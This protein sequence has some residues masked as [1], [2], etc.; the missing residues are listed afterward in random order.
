MRRSRLKRSI[1][2]TLAAT[3]LTAAP[4]NAAIT[5]TVTGDEL[6]VSSD[7]AGDSI[8]LTCSSGKVAVNGAAISGNPSCFAIRWVELHGN[9]GNDTLD[10]SSATLSQYYLAAMP[11]LYGDAGNDTLKGPTYDLGSDA[12][13]IDAGDGDDTIIDGPGRAQIEP[14]SGTNTIDGGPGGDGDE[15][16]VDTTAGASVSA[17]TLTYGASSTTLTSVDFMYV[18]GGPAAETF[19]FLA[20]TGARVFLYAGGG[21]DTIVGSPQADTLKGEAGSD[22][23]GGGGG[24]DYVEGGPGV[25][26]VY[27]EGGDDS[28]MG[29]DLYDLDPQPEVDHLYGGS[30]NDGLSITDLGA[31]GTTAEGGSGDDKFV[32]ASPNAAMT[33]TGGADTDTLLMVGSATVSDT[34]YGASS[35]SGVEKLTSPNALNV[36]ARGFSGSTDLTAYQASATLLGGTGTNV[37]KGSTQADTLRGGPGKDTITGLGG[38]DTI[39][40]GTGGTDTLDGGDGDDGFAAANSAPTTILCG[41]G[42]DTATRDLSD[43]VTACE[44]VTPADPSPPPPDPSVPTTTTTPAPAPAPTV[45]TTPTP[46]PS[47]PT[48]PATAQAEKPQVRLLSRTLRVRNGKVAVRVSCPA[49]QPLCRVAVAAKVGRTRFI[50]KTT[51]T[52]NSARTVTRSLKVTRSGLSKLRRLRP[53]RRRVD[54]EIQA[55]GN[56]KTVSIAVRLPT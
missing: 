8:V 11:T 26:N 30:G 46:T 32:V 36:D 43:T 39:S 56:T 29:F 22:T 7:G 16:S 3:A 41:A 50:T 40:A 45:P 9:G 2:L 24:N 51:F 47:V 6:D 53:S 27:G 18:N 52:V 37:L 34:A 44:S 35:M 4:A 17:N 21:T 49:S 10:V 12:T 19:D 28:V 20:L 14:G 15:I 1:L 54:L 48:T 25:D 55:L 38:N 33:L 42:T 13:D 31:A 23:I 5:T